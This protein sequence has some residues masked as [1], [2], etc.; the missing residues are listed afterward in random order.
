MYALVALGLLA[1]GCD[2]AIGTSERT[3]GEFAQQR[4]AAR[5]QEMAATRL[6]ADG[7]DLD[8]RARIAVYR[9]IQNDPDSISQLKSLANE[10]SVLAARVLATSFQSGKLVEVDYDQAASWL[11]VAANFGDAKSA[12]ELHRYRTS[13]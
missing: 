11:E 13:V 7:G 6:L 10:G 4:E 3:A 2:T 12:L 5:T 1:S 8:A 9:W